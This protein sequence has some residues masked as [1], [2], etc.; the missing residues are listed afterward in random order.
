M[1]KLDTGTVGYV[2][3]QHFELGMVPA[4]GPLGV[5]GKT[6]PV[7]D[8]GALSFP[9]FVLRMAREAG[10]LSVLNRNSLKVLG[11]VEVVRG[12]GIVTDLIAMSLVTARTSLHCDMSAEWIV[13]GR[14]VVL[15]TRM[16]RGDRTIR[17]PASVSVTEVDGQDQHQ[18]G[19]QDHSRP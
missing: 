4:E 5:T 13:T 7:V 15:E 8:L 19:G 9:S 18:N 12:E 16:S 14:T 6:E 2:V 11:T 17:Y 3:S 1:G 10:D